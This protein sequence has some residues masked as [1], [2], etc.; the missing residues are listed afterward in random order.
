MCL[1]HAMASLALELQPPHPGPKVHHPGGYGGSARGSGAKL[2]ARSTGREC[3]VLPFANCE[4]GSSTGH[5][6]GFWR[7]CGQ[8][9]TPHVV[10]SVHV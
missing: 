3:L 2:A 8:Y 9:L 7:V 10:V 5:K 6:R 1:Y 4:E